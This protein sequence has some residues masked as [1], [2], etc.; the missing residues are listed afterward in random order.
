MPVLSALES[1]FSFLPFPRLSGW[2]LLGQPL[3]ERI[4]TETV[5]E[6]CQ[7]AIIL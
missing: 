3:L 4:E 2:H 6:L 1:L 7:E 5:I